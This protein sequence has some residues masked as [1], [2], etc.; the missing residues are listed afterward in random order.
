MIR[1]QH[2]KMIFSQNDYVWTSTPSINMSFYIS[3]HSAV[4]TGREETRLFSCVEFGHG[5]EQPEQMELHV[6]GDG[7][8]LPPQQAANLHHEQE[9]G[10]CLHLQDTQGEACSLS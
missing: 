6:G 2:Q 1:A 9:G 4:H 10:T 7:A 3:V 8:F 5:G